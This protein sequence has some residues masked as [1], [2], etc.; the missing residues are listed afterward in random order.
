MHKNNYGNKIIPVLMKSIW[1]KNVLNLE[2]SVY[3]SIK[4]GSRSA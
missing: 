3:A 1:V 2:A 4:S